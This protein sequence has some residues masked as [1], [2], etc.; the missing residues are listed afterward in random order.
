MQRKKTE[1]RKEEIKKAVLE[2]IANEGLS[3][4]STKNLAEKVG[5]SEGAIFKHFRSKR[6]I[7][8]SIME[9]VKLDLQNALRN[10][11][12]E[13]TPAEKRFRKFLCA[14]IDYLYHHQGITIFLFSEAAHM[15]DALIKEQLSNILKEQ[16]L[17]V[18]KI[19]RDGKSEGVFNKEVNE[20]D[21]ATLY[22]GI[23]LSF[24]VEIVLNK[25]RFNVKK[26]CKTMYEQMMR[27]L[28]N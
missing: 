11:S 18:S 5:I 26:F 16:K 21:I 8:L 3:K 9:D 28:K 13:I 1:I 2:I 19:V 14:H 4:L 24:N 23:P 17:L 15:D 12:I 27:I 25:N 22:S 10:I 20:K 7:L 6:D